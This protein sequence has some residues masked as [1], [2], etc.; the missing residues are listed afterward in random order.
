MPATA[1]SRPTSR[2]FSPR[3]AGLTRGR[4]RK[5]CWPR[6]SC[7][8]AGPEGGHHGA[9]L[10]DTA[11]TRVAEQGPAFADRPEA[12][13][14]PICRRYALESQRREQDELLRDFGVVF[15]VHASEQS[16]YDGGKIPI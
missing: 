4:W 5:R 15:Q 1:T 6:S 14:L 10:A 12:E 16:L 9:Y 13:A 8:R 3:A 11:D 7:P 2:W